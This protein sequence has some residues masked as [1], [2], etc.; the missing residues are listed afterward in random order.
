MP[1]CLW[2]DENDMDKK[3]SPSFSYFPVNRTHRQNKIDIDK[4]IK[5]QWNIW[6][7]APFTLQLVVLQSIS[8]FGEKAN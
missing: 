2:A 8:F 4:K 3:M 5:L 6:I 1:E 7:L